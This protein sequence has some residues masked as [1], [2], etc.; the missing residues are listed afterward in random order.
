M[1]KTK[2]INKDKDQ[3]QH[4]Y[5]TELFSSALPTRHT[6]KDNVTFKKE[7]KRTLFILLF[8]IITKK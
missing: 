1:A 2:P 6:Q 4:N 7:N 8:N 5:S 3:Q